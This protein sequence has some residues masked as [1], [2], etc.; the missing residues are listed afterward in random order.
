MNAAVW[1]GAAIFFTFGVAAVPFS[2]EMKELL[3]PK[4]S[5]YFPGAIAQIFIA[6]YF[7]LQLFCGT[8][9]LLHLVAEWIYLGRT[10]RGAWLGLLI[11]LVVAGLIGGYWLQP[12]MKKLHT[13]KYALN[14]APAIRESAD[15]S[16]RAWHGISQAVNLAMLVGLAIYLWRIGNPTDPTRFVSTSKFRG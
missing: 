10:P 2:P 3:G 8:I 14:V 4:T 11:A 1:F 12:K 7:H 6:R 9:A 5:A 15:H 13:A 16:F